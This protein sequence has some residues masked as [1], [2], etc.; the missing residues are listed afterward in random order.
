MFSVCLNPPESCRACGYDW[1]CR[2]GHAR[3]RRN[4]HESRVNGN[5]GRGLG[6]EQM[7]AAEA[8]SSGTQR[9]K[10]D[11]RSTSR[12]TRT[13]WMGEWMDGLEDRMAYFDWGKCYCY[14]DPGT[15]YLMTLSYQVVCSWWKAPLPPGLGLSGNRGGGSGR[16][17]TD[18]TPHTGGQGFRG[19]QQASPS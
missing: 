7:V 9:S 10:R 14:L 18:G 12:A 8:G 1:W 5:L 13:G 16:G 2:P 19:N 17:W 3:V 4:V 15:A 11:E 6:G